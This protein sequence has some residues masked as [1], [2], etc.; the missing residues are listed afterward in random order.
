M[1]ARVNPEPSAAETTVERTS[2]KKKTSSAQPRS[3]EDVNQRLAC[4]GEMERQLRSLR[5]QFEQH[6]AVLKQQWVEASQPVT[7]TKKE[8]EEQIECFYWAH[9]EEVLGQGRKS[10]DLAFGRLGTRRSRTL[11]VDNAA[12]AQEWLA[13]HGLDRYLRVRTELDRE[14]LRSALLGSDDGSKESAVDLRGCPGIR[15][16]DGEEFWYDA[17][18]TRRS[19]PEMAETPT[20]RKPAAT[21]PPRATALAAF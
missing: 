12:A 10:M 14:A 18:A 4:L 15:L 6:V 5:D 16:H 13:R 19:V 7:H 20:L 8:L 17:D 2:R 3:W 1:N 9:R 21:Q 11:A